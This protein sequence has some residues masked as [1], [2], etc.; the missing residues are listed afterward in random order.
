[1][2]TMTSVLK[3]YGKPDFLCLFNVRFAPFARLFPVDTDFCVLRRIPDNLFH[4][5]F[6]NR[7]AA[8]RVMI[9]SHTVQKDCRALPVRAFLI[10]IQC[11][12]IVVF[13]IIGNQVL[14]AHPAFL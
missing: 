3:I 12:R 2:H 10:I 8:H 13:G 1:M 6:G 14:S 11:E 5:L 9:F 4:D 7:D